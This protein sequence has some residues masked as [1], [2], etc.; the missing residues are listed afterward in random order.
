MHRRSV[1]HHL[2]SGVED[3]RRCRYKPE[4]EKDFPPEDVS[5]Q[6][7]NLSAYTT[8]KDGGRVI[9]LTGEH[10]C[11]FLNENK[12]CKLV[13]AYGENVLS[14]TCAVFPREVHRFKTHEEE[15][16]MP[17]VRQSLTCCGKKNRRRI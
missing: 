2:L 14:E 9:E 12:L 1:Y 4:M 7:K 13:T 17:A 16:L 6:K 3:R 5:P 15:T 10:K 8:K 11:P